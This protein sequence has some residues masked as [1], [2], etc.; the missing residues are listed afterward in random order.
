MQAIDEPI[1]VAQRRHRPGEV[2]KER[3]QIREAAPVRVLARGFQP[4]LNGHAIPYLLPRP[5]TRDPRPANRESRIANR[6]LSLERKSTADGYRYCEEFVID[7]L[8]QMVP[9]ELD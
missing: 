2:F 1:G 3:L 5:A 4:T 9:R 6:E 7:W 8:A